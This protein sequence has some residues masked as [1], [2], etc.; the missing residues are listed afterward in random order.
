MIESGEIK[1]YLKEFAETYPNLVTERLIRGSKV[2]KSSG[3]EY[4]I[5]DCDIDKKLG[6]FPDGAVPYGPIHKHLKGSMSEILKLFNG[7]SV[8]PFSKTYELGVGECLEKAIL[9][10]LSAQRD[11]EAFLIIGALSQ[12]ENVGVDCHAYNVVFKDE[13]PFLVDAEN[14]VNKYSSGKIILPYIAPISGIMNERYPEFEVPEEWKFGRAY[15][16]F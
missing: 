13:K 6:S 7:N 9:V 4:E 12:D 14:P 10:Q 5:D 2:K 15:L 1:Q 11:R 16:L 8:I 3:L